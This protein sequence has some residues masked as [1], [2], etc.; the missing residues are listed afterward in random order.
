MRFNGVDLNAIHPAIGRSHEFPP[1]MPRRS[2]ATVAGSTGETVVNV[3]ASQEEYTVRVNIAGR[4]YQEAMEARDRLAEWA[5]SSGKTTA[6][7]EPTH[8]RGRAYDAIFKSC[9]KI[10]KRF[11]T[12]D[13]VF[14][15]PDGGVQYETT[16]RHAAGA[17]SVAMAIGG[18]AATY[19]DVISLTMNEEAEEINLTLDGAPYVKLSGGFDAGDVVEIRPRTDAVLV[20]GEHDESRIDFT[21]TFS[22]TDLLPG[23]HEL[24]AQ[25]AQ[26]TARWHNRWR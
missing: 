20:N 10:E 11:G 1:G 14:M 3:T 19:P 12:V 6:R 4:S 15:L 22:D 8:A 26:I 25:N 24:A 23:R 17:D 5:C 13:V 2:I 7:L 16:E 21:G 9:S 18:T